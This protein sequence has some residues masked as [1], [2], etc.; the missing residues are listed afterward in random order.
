MNVLKKVQAIDPAANF[1]HPVYGLNN[2]PDNEADWIL[3][4]WL[5]GNGGVKPAYA[6]LVAGDYPAAYQAQLDREAA[7]AAARPK[8]S[9]IN[10]AKDAVNN[11]SSVAALRTAVAN[12]ILLMDAVLL[13][14][15]VDVDEEN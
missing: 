12:L 7:Q 8:R 2:C 15:D 13:F 14:Q 5:N 9:Q 1:R 6:A 4:I 11:A 10:A 3:C